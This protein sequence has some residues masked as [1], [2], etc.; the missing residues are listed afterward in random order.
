VLH[1]ERTVRGYLGGL[2]ANEDALPTIALSKTEPA[3]A[4]VEGD[5]VDQSG[6]ACSTYTSL[7]VTPPDNTD[8]QNI[9]V[10]IETCALQVHPIG[11]TT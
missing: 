9:P 3:L 2:P 6:N 8:T 4:V 10:T 1:A 7:R 11:S 5:A